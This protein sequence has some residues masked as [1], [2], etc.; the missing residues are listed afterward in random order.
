VNLPNP[1]AKSDGRHHD[2]HSAPSEEMKRLAHGDAALMLIECLMVTLIEQRI[3]TTQ[4]I[5]DAVEAAI[6][7]K[8]QMVADQDHPEIALV[9]AG[10]LSTLANSLAAAKV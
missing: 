6:A 2:G 3:L 9:A 4:E 10:L 5:V 8:R 1:P 7:T